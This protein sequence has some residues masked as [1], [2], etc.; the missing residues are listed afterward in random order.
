MRCVLII[1]V[2][3]H[4]FSRCFL[5]EFAQCTSIIIIIIDGYLAH[6]SLLLQM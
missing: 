2:D 5:L 6:T 1:G 3:L 4:E